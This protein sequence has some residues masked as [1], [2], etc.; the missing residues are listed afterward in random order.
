MTIPKRTSE[1]LEEQW[2]D[3]K[4]AGWKDWAAAGVGL[5]GLAA[6]PFTGGGSDAAAAAIDGSLL[7]ADA[8]ATGAAATGADAAATGAAATETAATGAGAAAKTTTYGGDSSYVMNPNGLYGPATAATG[9]D[10]AAGAT[11]GNGIKGLAQKLWNKYKAPASAAGGAEAN[12][13]TSLIGGGGGITPNVGPYGGGS[14]GGGPIQI[15]R[16]LSSKQ[17]ASTMEMEILEKVKDIPR[18]LEMILET[19]CGC[20]QPTSG[21]FNGMPHCLP[22]SGCSESVAFSPS[23][24]TGDACCSCGNPNCSGSFHGQP[25][26]APGQGCNDHWDAEKGAR[27]WNPAMETPSEKIKDHDDWASSTNHGEFEMPDGDGDA[28]DRPQTTW[29]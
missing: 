25:V 10:A 17:A 27:K 11:S 19:I 23:N 6:T 4:E 8:A 21:K 24:P 12:K 9:A 2:L 7:G 16:M 29:E 5:L 13:A 28:D 15:G 3:V 1:L 22:G 14:G 20:G 26:C 18:L